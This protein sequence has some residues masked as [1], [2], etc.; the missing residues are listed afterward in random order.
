MKIVYNCSFGGFSL[1]S[2]IMS[3]L[4]YGK[5]YT[6]HWDR[7]DRKLIELLEQHPELKEEEDLEIEEIP[8]TATD[9]AICEYDG[10]E[11]VIYVIDGKIISTDPY[12]GPRKEDRI[13]DKFIK[14]E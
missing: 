10:A 9:W 3:K 8:D 6:Y 12:S 4:G 1:G 5:T 13:P 11:T 7:T 14:E 2:D